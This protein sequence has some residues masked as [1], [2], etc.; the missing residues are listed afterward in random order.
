MG[1]LVELGPEQRAAFDVRPTVAKHNLCGL[2]LFSEEEIIKLLDGYP[3]E[4]L[5]A[6]SMGTDPTRR[7]QNRR[8]K[9]EGLSGREL[10]DAVVKGRLWLNVTNADRVDRRY[11]ELIDQLYGEIAE[12]VPG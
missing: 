6:I 4:F 8:A 1:N 3:P 10:Y 2:S 11:R 7:D 5:F 9:H 12:Q